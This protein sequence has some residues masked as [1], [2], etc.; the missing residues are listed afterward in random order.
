MDLGRLLL[1]EVYLSVH[2]LVD[3][4]HVAVIDDSGQML[5]G[6]FVALQSFRRNILEHWFLGLIVYILQDGLHI[7]LLLFKLILVLL[8]LLLQLLQVVLD[9]LFVLERFLDLLPRPYHVVL[10]VQLLPYQLIQ[11]LQLHLLVPPQIVDLVATPAVGRH[12]FVVFL[13]RHVQLVLHLF[14]LLAYL[15]VREFLRVLLIMVFVHVEHLLGGLAF[16]Q[17]GQIMVV[18]V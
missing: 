12:C 11:R 6:S 15:F 18:F 16:L 1:L 4:H 2:L 10:Q 9:L 13:Q 7:L 8:R 3:A 17:L 14:D 5:P